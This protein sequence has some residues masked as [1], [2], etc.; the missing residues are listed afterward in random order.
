M[1]LATRLERLVRHPK[2]TLASLA[3]AAAAI[4]VAIGSGASFTS[5]GQNPANTFT[6]GI[7]QM[8]NSRANAAV[9]TAANMKPGAPPQTGAVDIQNTG[10]MDMAV[11]LTRDQLSSTDTGTSNPSPFADKVNLTVTDC[12]AYSGAGT[13]PACGD[14]D[15]RVVYGPDAS[16]SAMSDRIELGT[17]AKDE[18]HRY[19]FAAALDGSTGNE[20]AGDGSSARFVWDSEQT[21]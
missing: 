7:V 13:P 12:G 5:Q 10:S 18:K 17:F 14:G 11:S 8:D 9:L 4:A 1:D 3:L 2:R 16:L 15:D 20:Y 21:P 6:A 19:R